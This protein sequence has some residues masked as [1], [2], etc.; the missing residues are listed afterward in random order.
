MLWGDNLKKKISLLIVATLLFSL[1]SGCGLNVAYNKYTNTFFDSFDTITQ[2]VGYTKTKE[3]FDEYATYIHDRMLELHKLFDKYN[4]Y[5]GINNIKTINDKAGIEPVVVEKEIMDMIIL[6]KELYDN[7]SHK[8]NIAFG[9]V[10]VIWSEYRDVAEENPANAKLP[11]MEDL[12]AASAHTD[13]EKVIIDV[14][15]STIYL[16]DPLMSLDVGAIAKGYAVELVARE[17]NEKGFDSFI[18]SGG[19]NIRAV[20]KP[21]DGERNKWGIG[22]QNPDKEVFSDGDNTLETVYINDDSVVSSGDYQRYYMVGDYRVHHIIDPDTLMPAANYRSVNVV[23]EDSGLADFYSTEVF[24][25]PYEESRAFV[26]S[27]DGLDAIWVFADGRI[28]MS[29]G[30]KTIAYSY[31]ARGTDK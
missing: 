24:L 16:E 1:I 8:T 13:I 29:E 21:M 19:G 9:A 20:G 2:V 15:K 12:V 31:G 6:S 27:V 26:D 3:E 5:E 14:E 18:I 23:I 10:L 4:N 25:L 28:E 7:T 11:P 30:F 17:V 22:I